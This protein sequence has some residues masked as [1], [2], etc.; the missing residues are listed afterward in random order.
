WV[1]ASDDLGSVMKLF[2]LYDIEE[3]PVIDSVDKKHIIGSVER[4]DII[5]IY[6]KELV[7]KNLSQE[8]SRSLKLL[9]KIQTVDFIDDYMIAELP[10]PASFI[11]KSIKEI[12]IRVKYGVQILMIKKKT[13]SGDYKQIV[14]SPGEKLVKEDF[15]VIMAKNKDIENFKHV[16]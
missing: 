6:N 11:G 10:I 9:D 2:G 12:D 8:F 13:E 5:N 7:K 1:E 4:K 14:P 15:L 16:S 3:I